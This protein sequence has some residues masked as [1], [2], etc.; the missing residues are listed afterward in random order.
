M[1]DIHDLINSKFSEY[2]A[3]YDT[4]LKN[5]IEFTEDAI[6]D[7]VPKESTYTPT[8]SNSAR[9][10]SK[11]FSESQY[12]SIQRKSAE[13]GKNADALAGII[14]H[15]SKGDTRAVNPVSG[16]TGLIQ[17]MKATAADLGT[18][19]DEIK[20]MSFDQ[21]LDLTGK[22]LQGFGGR[23]DKAE[24]ATDL[25]SLVFYP[26]MSGKA[27]DYVLGQ[28]NNRSGIV[29]KQNSI[30]DLNK[31]NKITKSEFDEWGAAKL[32]RGGIMYKK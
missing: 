11:L 7:Y 29:A 19:H 22:Y 6:G 10:Y 1:G 13:L 16:A 5:K 25:Y 20:E 15:E 21:Q 8:S 31:D 4:E 12:A 3:G 27:D 28:H 18:S 17:F 23:F 2:Y 14:W 24:T 30:F 9:D 26:A 32:Q